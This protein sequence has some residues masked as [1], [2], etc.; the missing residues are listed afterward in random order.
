MSPQEPDSAREQE[1]G[2]E[3]EGRNLSPQ[4]W[5]NIALVLAGTVLGGG[6]G[7][8]ADSL[9]GIVGPTT[10]QAR[11]ETDAARVQPCVIDS[12]WR[13]SVDQRLRSLTS[14]VAVL[15]DR[16]ERVPEP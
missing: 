6:G 5:R 2:S 13:A 16:S 1:E 9:L 7:A 10:E 14:D 3:V 8:L 11:A 12:E 15:L 4:A